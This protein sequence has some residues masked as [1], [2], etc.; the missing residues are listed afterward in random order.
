VWKFAERRLRVD[1]T[2]TRAVNP[3]NG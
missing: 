3:P 2:E 1:W